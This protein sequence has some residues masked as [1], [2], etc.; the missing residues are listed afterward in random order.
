[1]LW[2]KAKFLKVGRP[3]TEPSSPSTIVVR[4][5][6][7]CKFASMTKSTEASVCPALL[8]TPP[9]LYFRGKTWPGFLKSSGVE[10]ADESVSTVF[11]LSAADIP[12]ETPALTS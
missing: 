5:E 10:M 11:A 7:G 12:V 8:R 9:S 2:S 1:M 6:T 4:T 3:A